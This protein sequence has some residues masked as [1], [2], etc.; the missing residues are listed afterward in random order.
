MEGWQPVFSHRYRALHAERRL[1]PY[2]IGHL[3]GRSNQAL[4]QEYTDN[5]FD[6]NAVASDSAR[7]RFRPPKN[8][9]YAVPA[10]IGVV[11]CFDFAKRKIQHVAFPYTNTVKTFE[12]DGIMRFC[13]DGGAVGVAR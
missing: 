5:Q 4:R 8:A 6:R 2:S 7:G 1:H 10:N 3:A 13:C 9:P 12:Y 11:R